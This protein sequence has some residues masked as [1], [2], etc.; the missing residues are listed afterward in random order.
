MMK[1]MSDLIIFLVVGAA[2][3]SLNHCVRVGDS[4]GDWQA[5]QKTNAALEDQLA[6]D[7]YKQLIETNK[8]LTAMQDFYSA[9]AHDETIW[10]N[11]DLGKNPEAGELPPPSKSSSSGE[12]KT[13]DTVF[14]KDIH[15]TRTILNKAATSKVCKLLWAGIV[16]PV[17]GLR[18]ISAYEFV[19]KKDVWEDGKNNMKPDDEI[20]FYNKVKCGDAKAAC[21]KTQNAT[22]AMMFQNGK[23]RSDIKGKFE[24]WAGAGVSKQGEEIDALKAFWGKSMWSFWTVDPTRCQTMKDQCFEADKTDGE[25][26]RCDAMVAACDAAKERKNTNSPSKIPFSPNIDSPQYKAF[27]KCKVPF[28]AGVSGSILEQ[29]AFVAYRKK[30]ITD[31][32]ILLLMA[33]LNLAGHHS[34]GEAW[35]GSYQY[36]NLWAEN[37]KT[38]AIKMLEVQPPLKADLTGCACDGNQCDEEKRFLDATRGVLEGIA[39]K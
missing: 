7:I 25:A 28:V 1:G 9:Y 11:T 5:L 34:L 39:A 22:F 10:A 16:N 3:V 31:E 18:G 12:K 6:F 24:A 2:C 29:L 13:V 30:N 33:V 8:G 36:V 35:T 27:T 19:F 23:G 26:L 14:N 17:G 38:N 32:L 37:Q 20:G 15:N 4:D 21:D